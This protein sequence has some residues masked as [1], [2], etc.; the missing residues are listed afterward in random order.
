M[1][2]GMPPYAAVLPS[3]IPSLI[4]QRQRAAATASCSAFCRPEAPDSRTGTALR[5]CRKAAASRTDIVLLGPRYGSVPPAP[6]LRFQVRRT[7]AK[8]GSSGK[9]IPPKVGLYCLDPTVNDRWTTTGFRGFDLDSKPEQ[10]SAR[11]AIL[12]RHSLF[13]SRIGISSRSFGGTCTVETGVSSV[14]V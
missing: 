14:S 7:S 2:E 11:P 9:L 5:T 6:N 4:V 1:A 3:S 8:P 12:T 13:L 10:I